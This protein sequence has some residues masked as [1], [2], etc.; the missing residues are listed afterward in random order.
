MPAP[1]TVAAA[2][3]PT[4]QV[5]WFLRNPE[6]QADE[7]LEQS[8]L[9][10]LEAERV[11][12]M[13]VVTDADGNIDQ[14]VA[15]RIE[16]DF[17]RKQWAAKKE[18][19]ARSNHWD[20]TRAFWTDYRWCPWVEERSQL[21]EMYAHDEELCQE[22]VRACGESIDE[23]LNH[24]RYWAEKGLAPFIR[25]REYAQDIRPRLEQMELQELVTTLVTLRSCYTNVR[26]ADS[27]LTLIN[28]DPI[29]VHEP[30]AYR[31]EIPTMFS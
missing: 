13:M 21:V 5:R 31:W 29:A 3:N 25:V 10:P 1:T 23:L 11:E 20:Q 9:A 28:P 24:A 22:L 16:D 19:A 8:L 15:R 17:E 26:L 7:D 2:M 14:D 4:L 12:R 6:R 30:N 18:L 27:A